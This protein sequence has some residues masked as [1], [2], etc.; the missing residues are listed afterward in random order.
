MLLTG[1]FVRAIDEKLRLA[2]PKR[3]RDAMAAGPER[4][5]FITPGTDRSL[6]IYTEESLSRMANRLAAA[7]P[8]GPEVR[9]FSRLFYA[10][11]QPTELDGQGRIRIPP[12]LAEL[13]GLRREAVLLGVQDHLELW[14]RGRWDAYLAERQTRYDEIAEAAFAAKKQAES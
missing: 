6:A 10:Q 13:V 5:L 9:A 4:I 8:A 7:S 2:I 12:E 1:T 14:D 11:A 3:I